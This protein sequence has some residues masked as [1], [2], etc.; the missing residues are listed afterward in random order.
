MAE[1]YLEKGVFLLII[2][3]RI[4]ISC[5]QWYADI[6]LLM[7]VFS[8]LLVIDASPLKN[9]SKSFF[10]KEVNLTDFTCAS[11][12]NRFTAMDCFLSVLI[13]K[14]ILITKHITFGRINLKFGL[15]L[16]TSI[17]ISWKKHFFVSFLNW[18]EKVWVLTFNKTVKFS[19]HLGKK[20]FRSQCLQVLLLKLFFL[21][22]I[23]HKK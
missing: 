4:I 5:L 1:L 13:W 11:S 14:S 21:L 10:S 6:L 22:C 23:Y 7:I 19:F 12:S 15:C 2:S 17:N 9:L 3:V 18:W 20:N 16:H 8:I